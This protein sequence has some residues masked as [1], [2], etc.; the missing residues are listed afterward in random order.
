MCVQGIE[1]TDDDHIISTDLLV[2]P[3]VAGAVVLTIE[4]GEDR[5]AFILV[6]V[7][8]RGTVWLDDLRVLRTGLAEQNWELAVICRLH[9]ADIPTIDR[10]LD[11]ADVV[12]LAVLRNVDALAS[13]LRV[14]SRHRA[15][16]RDCIKCFRPSGPH[17][18]EAKPLVEWI[19]ERDWLRISAGVCI[20]RTRGVS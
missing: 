2:R 8:R 1:R 6:E 18:F 5:T 7:E 16:V 3:L 17:S 19:D 10:D 9:F 13:S 14:L 12:E 4:G 20:D 11:V 15:A